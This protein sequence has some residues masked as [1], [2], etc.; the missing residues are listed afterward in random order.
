MN[1]IYCCLTIASKHPLWGYIVYVFLFSFFQFIKY[2]T[3]GVIQSLN[4][5]GIGVIVVGVH[6]L[7]IFNKD[8]RCM[9]MPVTKYTV[10]LLHSLIHLL[11]RDI[12]YKIKHE[13]TGI[14]S[15]H[16]LSY[17]KIKKSVATKPEIDTFPIQ[18]A[19]DYIG[20]SHAWA[21]GTSA[22][23]NAG[24][25]KYYRFFTYRTFYCGLIDTGASIDS[26]RQRNQS[27]V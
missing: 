13:N 3:Q 10:K 25:I 26:N 6:E 1:A 9:R 11:N 17:S 20:V 21:G 27:V 16:H 4:F 23:K 7:W 2:T 5:P 14:Y 19:W 18:T 22:L 15:S 12:R 8:N 24:S